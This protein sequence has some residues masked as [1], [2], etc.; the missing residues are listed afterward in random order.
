MY[1]VIQDNNLLNDQEDTFQDYIDTKAII[2][3]EVG[4]LN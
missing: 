1:L 3:V 4:E 2:L